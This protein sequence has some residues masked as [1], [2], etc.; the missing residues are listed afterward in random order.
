MPFLYWVT[1]VLFGEPAE[2]NMPP[3]PPWERAHWGTASYNILVIPFALIGMAERFRGTLRRRISI[4]KIGYWWSLLIIIAGII[5]IGAASG[6]WLRYS[7]PLV[8]AVII[9][10]LSIVAQKK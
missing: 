5:V 6:D 9:L 7:A 4:S 1:R 2:L 3:E 10:I 8:I